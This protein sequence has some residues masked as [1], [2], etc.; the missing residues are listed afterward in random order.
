MHADHFD[1]P[2]HGIDRRGH[3][4]RFL[5]HLIVIGILFVLPEVISS[6]GRPF[7]VPWQITVGIYSKSLVF[8]ALFYLN[9]YLILP[10]TRA[11]GHWLWSVLSWNL[12]AIAVALVL[13]WLISQWTEP[14]WDSLRPPK[15]GHRHHQVSRRLT[16]L[17]A[18]KFMLRDLVMMV[19]SIALSVALKLSDYWHN[20][21]RR[22]RQII[23]DRRQQE[24]TSLKNQLNP[25]F[26]FNTLNTIYALIAIS[27]DTAQRAVHELSDMLRYVLYDNRP[28]VELHREFH[29]ADTYIGLM[30]LRMP[31]DQQL[32]FKCEFAPAMADT[33]IAPLLFVAL[34]ENVFKHGN[35]GNP[36]DRIAIIITAADGIVRCHTE[37]RISNSR[38]TLADGRNPAGGIG[39]QNL[40]RRLELIYGK[41]VTFN[42]GIE[43]S[44]FVADLTINT[45]AS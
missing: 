20:I 8:I 21:E 41:N 16:L 3:I 9:Y 32:D 29:F 6:I 22:S 4:V 35:T 42:T 1:L 2:G 13:L 45:S 31:P 33:M 34:I 26:L 40:R 24:L 44:V 14:F 12:L 19:L 17:W 25:H 11:K 38:H 30:K 23:A 7:A 39:L 27:P 15:P 28:M 43:N 10:R 5:I 36:A 18:T 37:N